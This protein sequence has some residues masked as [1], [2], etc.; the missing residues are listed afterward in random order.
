MRLSIISSE[1]RWL[2]ALSAIVGLTP[3]SAQRHT[4]DN[5]Q[6]IKETE[7]VIVQHDV[8]EITN[9]HYEPLREAFGDPEGG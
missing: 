4:L 8:P 7:I 6:H 1:R 2:E 3:R 9:A 5:I